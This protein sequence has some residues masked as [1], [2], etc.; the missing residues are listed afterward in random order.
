MSFI[1]FLN[2]FQ[3]KKLFSFSSVAK[4]QL[5]VDSENT[6]INATVIVIEL[7]V[8]WIQIGHISAKIYEC[9]LK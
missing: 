5:T 6:K 8:I 9:P 2:V 1:L 7:F 4:L 3:K